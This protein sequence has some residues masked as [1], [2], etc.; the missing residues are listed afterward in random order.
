M[1]LFSPN[2]LFLYPGLVVALIGF[3]AG[4]LIVFRPISINQVRFGID[5]LIYCGF[6]IAA[7]FQ[8][9]LFSVLS[10]VYAVQERLYPKSVSERFFVR[11]IS[12][13]WGLIA[14]FTVFLAGFG[15]AIYALFFWGRRGFGDL[16]T[17]HIAR[18]VV[19]SSVAMSLGIEIILSSF[20]MSTLAL[21]VRN[22]ST[23]LVE[24]Y[25]AAAARA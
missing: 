21:G 15:S 6:L 17:E 1:L 13:E 23:T 22:Y 7:G 19:P 14:G 25:K 20:L 12:L 24:E 5:T 10:R 18:L 2:L 9:V 8:A 4:G 16:V 11:N 3:I